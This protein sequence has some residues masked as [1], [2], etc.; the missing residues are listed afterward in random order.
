MCFFVLPR[1]LA[2]PPGT[3]LSIYVASL[4]AFLTVIVALL[5]AR[6][7]LYGPRV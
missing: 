1:G 5:V 6:N 2:L 3:I 7:K 4:L